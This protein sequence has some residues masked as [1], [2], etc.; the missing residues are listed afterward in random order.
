MYIKTALYTVFTVHV[1]GIS[2]YIVQ[3][4]FYIPQESP[5]RSVADLTQNTRNLSNAQ[6]VLE[7]E[8]R[9]LSEAVQRL[10]LAASREISAEVHSLQCRVQQAK[11]CITHDDTVFF[12]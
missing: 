6:T 1:S 5:G 11:V 3:I 12:P 10:P 7:V 4:T 2:R 8:V 9:F